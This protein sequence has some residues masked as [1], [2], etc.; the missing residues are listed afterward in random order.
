MEYIQCPHCQKKY[1]VSDKLRAAVGKRIRCKHCQET[2]AIFIQEGISASA[3]KKI[4]AQQEVHVESDVQVSQQE[5]HPSVQVDTE[6]GEK[7]AKKPA[8]KT[9]SR[10]KSAKKPI[11][12]QLIIMLIL[13]T[14]LITASVAAY[15]FYYHPELLQSEEESQINIQKP[16]TVPAFTSVD[17]FA[18]KIETAEQ[19][20]ESIDQG[21][22]QA[23]PAIEAAPK[24][25]TTDSKP[26]KPAPRSLR[27]GP[28]NPSQVCKDAA[29]DYWIR[30][31]MIA[32][33]MLTNEAYHKLLR[34]GLSQ[35]KEIRKHCK[36]RELVA[37]LA[38][39][40]KKEDVPEWIE[41]EIISRTS[42]DTEPAKP[43]SKF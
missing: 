11:N 4:D 14:A 34:Q 22:E 21:V 16:V 19:E 43:T 38:E 15:I 42:G 25:I 23:A 1:G 10:K 28:E 35:T 36:H 27:D 8:K 31:S 12:M 30:T 29:A 33:S 9:K 7:K 37:V 32:N 39:A 5:E 3:Q 2:F 13:G 17:P 20:K 24:Q 18:G 41:A 6:K 40:A 26:E